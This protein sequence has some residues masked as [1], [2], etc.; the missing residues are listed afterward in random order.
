MSLVKETISVE[1]QQT[2]KKSVEFKSQR[3]SAKTEY[4]KNFFNKKL[5]NNNVKLYELLEALNR[6]P[7]ENAPS[8]TK[9]S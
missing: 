9:Q 3:D 5:K 4:K 6:L 1:I 7:K 2:V 8:E